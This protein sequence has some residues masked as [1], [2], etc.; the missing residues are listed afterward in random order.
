MK[1]IWIINHYASINSG[2][3]ASLAKLFVEKG[4]RTC[5][6]LS[7][8][9]HSKREY[10]YEDKIKVVH[11]DD[12]VKYV[13]IHSKPIYKGNGIGRI[14]NMIS[15]CLL[16]FRNITYIIEQVGIPNYIIASSVHPFVWEVGYKVAKKYNSK[17]IAEIRDIW[18]LSLIEVTN[19]SP[20]HPFIKLLGYIE[21]RAYLR[22]DAIVST[23]PFAYDHIC[24]NFHINKEKVHWM[25][26]GIDVAQYERNLNGNLSI[27]SDLENFL[28]SH[29]C[30]VYTGS[31]V[32]S[33]CIPM[34]LE[35]FS[36]LK[37]EDIY[38]AIIGDGHDKDAL[39][40][41]KETLDLTKVEFFP[42]VQQTLIAKILSKAKCCVGAIHDKPLYRYGLS[43]NKLSDYLISGQPV[44]FACNYKNVVKDAGQ[45]SIP[46]DDPLKFADTIRT[47]RLLDEDALS[48]LS[49]KS[50]ELIKG[51]YD[52]DV[53]SDNYLKLLKTL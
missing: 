3:H 42:F 29:W 19:I 31:L 46:S 23:M 22:S 27:P 12:G 10:L 34:M 36:T 4:N 5:I 49:N 16:I 43:L 44:V 53:V 28:N 7:S 6:L 8:F 20:S 52:Y 47:I 41:Q 14:I 18:P 17:F 37:D 33:E 24:T 2:R 26:N 38:F 30:C 45:F 1:N 32:E 48:N 9:D 50:R 40:Q 39:L 35:A 13:Y 15:F 25:P 21:K 51:V 11:N